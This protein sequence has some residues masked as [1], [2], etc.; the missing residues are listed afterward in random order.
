ML[1]ATSLSVKVCTFK[2]NCLATANDMGPHIDSRSVVCGWDEP[3]LGAV[4]ARSFL[5]SLSPPRA[6]RKLVLALLFSPL[7]PLSQS[8]AVPSRLYLCLNSRFNFVLL[9]LSPLT[10]SPPV[11]RG[12]HILLNCNICHLYTCCLFLPTCMRV[13]RYSNITPVIFSPS[14][15]TVQNQF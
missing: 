4:L 1:R 11:K 13:T 5:F 2:S 6:G 7:L 14:T 3:K 15:V 9:S 8:P 10:R 12:P